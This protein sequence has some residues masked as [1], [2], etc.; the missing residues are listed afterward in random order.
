[1]RKKKKKEAM[2]ELLNPGDRESQSCAPGSIE[3]ELDMCEEGSLKGDEVLHQHGLYTDDEPD[4][5]S[6]SLDEIINRRF[7]VDLSE[8][9]REGDEMTGDE[10]S[11]GLQGGEPELYYQPHLETGF[12]GDAT[13]RVED[14]EKKLDLP[15]EPTEAQIEDS[16]TV[17]IREKKHKKIKKSS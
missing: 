6:V 9:R 12:P 4:E 3:Q 16:L 10:H 17:E 15:L 13:R 14:H 11:S 5:E 1:M 8:E 7:S 2:P